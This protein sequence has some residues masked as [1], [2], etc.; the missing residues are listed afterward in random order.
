MDSGKFGQIEYRFVKDESGATK[1]FF[2][3]SV[4]GMIKTT[5]S[6]DTVQDSELPFRLIVEARDNPAAP[7]IESNTDV[8]HVVVSNWKIF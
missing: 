5:R 1:Y 2:I 3:D 8:A 6:L 4:S 7:A